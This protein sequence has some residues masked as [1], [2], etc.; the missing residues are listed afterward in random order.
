MRLNEMEVADCTSVCGA[1]IASF[2]ADVSASSLPR[3]SNL[4]PL[5][6][7]FPLRSQDQFGN[8]SLLWEIPLFSP[9]MLPIHL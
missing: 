2:A 9:R 3:Q 8:N 1:A 7:S 4:F 5:G 6:I